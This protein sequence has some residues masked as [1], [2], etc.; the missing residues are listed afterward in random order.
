M[1]ILAEM[2]SCF[3]VVY[4]TTRKDIQNNLL[5]NYIRFQD[6]TGMIFATSLPHLSRTLVTLGL[7][8]FPGTEALDDKMKYLADFGSL[9]PVPEGTEGTEGGELKWS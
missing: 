5:S 9:H 3:T 7:F 6:G 1:I 4:S 8:P 2:L